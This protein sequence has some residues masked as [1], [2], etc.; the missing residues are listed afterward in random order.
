MLGQDPGSGLLRVR[1]SILT[2]RGAE[3]GERE[4]ERE[5]EGDRERD[6]GGGGEGGKEEGRFDRNVHRHCEGTRL[7]NVSFFQLSEDMK[8]FKIRGCESK[9]VGQ[10]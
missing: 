3:V 9:A 5:K 10:H 2:G 1:A 6:R 8:F 7:F 4:T